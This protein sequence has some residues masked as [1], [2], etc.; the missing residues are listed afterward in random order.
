MTKQL[1]IIASAQG[2][3]AYGESAENTQSNNRVLYDKLKAIV[4]DLKWVD[5]HEDRYNFRLSNG[6]FTPEEFSVLVADGVTFTEVTSKK[7][8][9]ETKAIQNFTTL[10]EKVEKL[11][12]SGNN[13]NLNERC[14]VHM[15]GQALANYNSTCLL[16]DICTD[17]LQRYLDNGWRIIAAC[18]QPD[19][20]RPDYILGRFNPHHQ[21]NGSGA[22]R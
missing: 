16:E 20:R 5:Y 22:E 21:S 8:T 10:E 19:Q 12:E 14:D 15:P 11:L 17:E 18:P 4:G 13:L 6:V 1:I 9:A 3:W 2:T 7:I